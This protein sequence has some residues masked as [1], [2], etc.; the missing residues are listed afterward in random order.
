MTIG[1]EQTLYIVTEGV[2]ASVEMC[3]IVMSGSLGREAIV[4]FL[5]TPG[6]ATSQRRFLNN[7]SDNLETRLIIAQL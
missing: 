5:T 1:F 7:I 4:T 2:D 6:S 3:A